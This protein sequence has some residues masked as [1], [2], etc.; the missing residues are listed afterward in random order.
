M[1]SS[2]LQLSA[3]TAA[4]SAGGVQRDRG[5]LAVVERGAATAAE[6]IQFAT[7]CAD[8]RLDDVVREVQ[9][10][11]RDIGVT[12][13]W[14]CIPAHLARG[15]TVGRIGVPQDAIALML[16]QQVVIGSSVGADP[17]APVSRLWRGLQRRADVM[18]DTRQCTTLPGSAA[19]VAGVERDVLLVSQR[20]LERSGP[21]HNG[22][23]ATDSAD[24]WT[25]A[26]ESAELVYRLAAVEQR[27]VLLVVPVGRATE[28][29]QHFSNA[30]ARQARLH[31]MTPPRTVKAGLLSALLTGNTGRERW[32][33]ASVMTIDDLAAMAAEAVGGT[34]PWP[35]ISIGRS[36]QFCG[37]PQQALTQMDAVP[38]LLVIE[39]LLRRAGH[40]EK[41]RLLL[42]AVRTTEAALHRTRE[43]WGAPL[44][45]PLR[46]YLQAIQSNW[47]RLSVA[48]AVRDRRQV[49][50]VG[51]VVSGLRL[52]IE[53]QLG[54]AEVRALVSASLMPAGLEVASVRSADAAPGSSTGVLDVRVRSRLGE[55]PLSDDAA[56]AMIQA[57]GT[58]VHCTSVEPWFPGA[59]ASADRARAG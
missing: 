4:G 15:G 57:L 3:A 42:Q 24:Q 18:I 59:S 50:R 30:L 38:L 40:L 33:V 35:V 12:L 31:R 22:T 7:L 32:L 49:Q 17:L 36:A 1:T 54:A 26:R 5:L 27:S 16:R 2:P 37:M 56:A 13:D 41:A 43:E 51:P 23:D 52:R 11:A 10:F 25:R 53:S 29:Q 47:G 46:A 55:P 9:L 44:E 39:Y 58:A 20:V 45:M 21:R 34:G 19:D 14:E 48:S 8:G 6:P 28:T